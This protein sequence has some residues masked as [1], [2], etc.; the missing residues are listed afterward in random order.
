MQS[1]LE[2][3]AAFL[4]AKG[5]L[6]LQ[7]HVVVICDDLEKL[8]RPNGC[9]AYAVIQTDVFFEFH[10]LLEAVE[11]CLKAIFVFNLQFPTASHMSWFFLQKA[12]FQITSKFDRVCRKVTQLLQDTK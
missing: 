10:S 8:H 3:K 9:I 5:D 6:N 4:Q 11:T 2:E 1:H 12:I 7:P